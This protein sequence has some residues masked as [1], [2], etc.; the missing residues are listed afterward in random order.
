MS[1]AEK[2]SDNNI[3][4]TDQN[5][6]EI[7][8]YD[9]NKVN[10]QQENVFADMHREDMRHAERMSH[11]DVVRTNSKT[12]KTAIILLIV[13]A[14]LGFGIW[15]IGYSSRKQDDAAK[16]V[17]TL[18]TQGKFDEARDEA[19]KL[20]SRGKGLW[21]TFQLNTERKRMLKMI[22]REEKAWYLSNGITVGQSAKSFREMKYT[23]A[24]KYLVNLGFK[25]KNITL[26]EIAY[27]D[28]S[29]SEK[30]LD[31]GTVTGISIGGNTKFNEKDK[32]D[33]D[34]TIEIYYTGKQ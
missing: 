14:I 8:N 34:S 29:R 24:Q 7:E 22:D 31:S 6:Q 20:K 32:F 4:V 9:E 10:Q 25:K 19:E 5:K 17:N 33:P 23:D 1:E 27:K 30:K 12:M 18:I 13:L 3:T 21:D 11:D 16:L 15:F 2:R 26:T 28:L